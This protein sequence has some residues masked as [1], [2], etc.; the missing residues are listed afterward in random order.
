MDTS[1]EVNQHPMALT[2]LRFKQNKMRSKVTS[3]HGD[4]ESHGAD[5]SRM[6]ATRHHGPTQKEENISSTFT[7]TMDDSIFIPMKLPIDQILYIIKHQPWVK[8]SKP[9]KH[10]TDPLE[11]GH[12]FFHGSRSTTPCIARS[13]KG[14]SRI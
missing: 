10:D 12:Y 13:P 9:T 14:V 4:P 5:P 3:P 2:D 6:R 1:P 8:L 7:K 11:V